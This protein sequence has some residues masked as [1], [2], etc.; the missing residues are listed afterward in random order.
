MCY[1]VGSWCNGT[2]VA[3]WLA[4]AVSSMA[5][6]L[7]LGV[8]FGVD[9]L[10]LYGEMTRGVSQGFYQ[11]QIVR[12]FGE[13]QKC[14]GFFLPKL[15]PVRNIEFFFVRQWEMC[16]ETRMR[17]THPT[18]WL[19]SLLRNVKALRIV[20]TNLS[21]SLH[22][23]TLLPSGSPDLIKQVENKR[24]S[25]HIHLFLNEIPHNDRYAMQFHMGSLHWPH[26][27][28]SCSALLCP[29]A[30]LVVMLGGFDFTLSVVWLLSFFFTVA[31]FRFLL[32]SHII[33]MR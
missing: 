27:M 7:P 26:K 32:R 25:S 10:L 28:K 30:M 29:A 17:M 13:C 15:A 18:N 23:V 22:T 24:K 6:W 21:W 14:R 8:N 19:E 16:S 9:F 11:L 12:A 20:C 31:C 3:P 33:N 1:V 5:A 2:A 4:I